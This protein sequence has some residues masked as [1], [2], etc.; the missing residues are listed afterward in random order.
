MLLRRPWLSMF[1]D[2]PN[3]MLR[4]KR[5]GEE[6]VF[7]LGQCKASACLVWP[8]T[9]TVVPGTNQEAFVLDTSQRARSMAWAAILDIDSWEALV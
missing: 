7:V 2:I 6:W 3:L 8:A 5:L 1:C 9:Q 4:D